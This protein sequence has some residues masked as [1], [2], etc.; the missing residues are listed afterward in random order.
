MFQ[1]VIIQSA[2]VPPD[3]VPPATGAAWYGPAPHYIPPD[4]VAGWVVVDPAAV[5]GG[6]TTLLGF[7]STQ[8]VPGGVVPP[9]DSD[10]L[11]APQPGVLA[12]TAVPPAQQRAGTDLS[13]TFEATRVT[14]FPPGAVAD[15]SNALNKI[16]INNWDE[17]NEL[18]FVEFGAGCCTPI[19]KTLSVE[20]TVD[21]EEMNSGAWS[22][23]IYSCA[24]PATL[25]I[26]P[27]VSS[28]GP[29][30]VT[31]TPRG[32]SGT[33]V[34]NTSMWPNCSYTAFLDTRPGLTTG[35]VDRQAIPDTLT[36]A[37]CD[38]TVTSL[39]AGITAIQTS[40]TVTSSVGFPATP[41]NVLLVSTWEIMTVTN[42]AGTTWTVVRGQ[43]GTSAAAA[44]AGATLSTS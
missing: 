39:A 6:F 13:I 25:A 43:G 42:V 22:L 4:P 5:G 28:P 33:I 36:F 9:K 32:G 31:V 44:V 1:D 27:T 35:L 34:E 29:P 21:H 8:V 37:I 2:P 41:F 17:V 24:L 14:T 23:G 16:H 30:P 26:T 3:P 12:G 18:N 11:Y 20:F 19:D 40:I 38:H 10:G 15:Y 7:D